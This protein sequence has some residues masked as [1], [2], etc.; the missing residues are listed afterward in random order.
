[1]CFGGRP[2]HFDQQVDYRTVFLRCD[3]HG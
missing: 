2:E 3:L 1:V